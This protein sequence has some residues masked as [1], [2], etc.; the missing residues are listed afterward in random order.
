MSKES[1][2]LNSNS[3][4]DPPLITLNKEDILPKNLQDYEILR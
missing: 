2:N 4:L 1:I 3:I